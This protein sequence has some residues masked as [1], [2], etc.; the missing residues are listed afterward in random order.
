MQR[1]L[2][3]K[4]EN[5]MNHFR[6][7]KRKY[8]VQ[9]RLE[10]DAARDVDQSKSE[11]K[12]ATQESTRSLSSVSS[13]VVR[14]TGETDSSI[15]E[16]RAGPSSSSTSGKGVK[17]AFS[18]ELSSLPFKKRR[19]SETAEESM[20]NN[21]SSEDAEGRS[22]DFDGTDLILCDRSLDEDALMV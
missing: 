7:K 22:S 5:F 14:F 20:V 6:M 9:L 16:V 17:R 10:T 21:W 8:S 12:D 2:F 1:F 15:D 19:Y 11:S 3:S 4:I 13:K 18:F